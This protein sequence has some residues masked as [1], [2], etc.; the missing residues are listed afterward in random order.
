ME[1]FAVDIGGGLMT[2]D[3][4][5]IVRAKVGIATVAA[6]ALLLVAT[7]PGWVDA[8]WAGTDG[9]ISLNSYVSSSNCTSTNCA[10]SST[11]FTNKGSGLGLFAR[12]D[13]GDGLYGFSKSGGVGVYGSSLT[14]SGVE[15]HGPTNGVYG[16]GGNGLYGV[17]T[18]N[19]VQAKGGTFGVFAEGDDYGVF[20]RAP[21]YGVFGQATAPGGTGVAAQADKDATALSVQGKA[22]FSRSGRAVVYGTKSTPKRRV[23]VLHVDLTSKSVVLATPQTNEPR[24][25]I[26][27]AIPRVSKNRIVIH[28]N[29]AVAR[30]YSIGWMVVERP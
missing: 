7:V 17:G 25:W 29:R 14:D 19:G 27:S 5:R 22:R 8:A 13:D 12:A 3:S 28:L 6:L 20:A 11:G 15:G 18:E 1:P 21:S 24:V 30:K 26:Q 4:Q 23:V 16:E 2:T 10:T 9:D